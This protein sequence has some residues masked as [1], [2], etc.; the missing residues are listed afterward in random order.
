MCIRITNIRPD[1][2]DARNKPQ[3]LTTVTRQKKWKEYQ[4]DNCEIPCWKHSH[5]LLLGETVSVNVAKVF[6]LVHSDNHMFFDMIEHIPS[7]ILNCSCFCQDA[8]L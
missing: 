4:H 5:I 1:F 8:H 6:L 7:N 2:L 3:F